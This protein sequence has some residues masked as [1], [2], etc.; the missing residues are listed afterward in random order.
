MYCGYRRMFA[1]IWLEKGRQK[2]TCGR[3]IPMR[4]SP[5][6][7]KIYVGS[8]TPGAMTLEQ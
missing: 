6:S 8:R 3:A 4:S 2:Y 5:W 7:N 1:R